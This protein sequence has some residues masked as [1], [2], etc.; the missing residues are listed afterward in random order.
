MTPGSS[1]FGEEVLAFGLAAG[2]RPLSPDDWQ[3]DPNVTRSS[4]V[5]TN[6]FAEADI[7]SSRSVVLSD[8]SLERCYLARR[9]G[10][11]CRTGASLA[12]VFLFSFADQCVCHTAAPER[13]DD[14]SDHDQFPY[15]L[16]KLLKD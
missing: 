2:A 4:T 13:C 14:H 16:V 5:T 1:G 6:N 12:P 3:P 10:A 11:G 15:H 7:I 9:A 8:F